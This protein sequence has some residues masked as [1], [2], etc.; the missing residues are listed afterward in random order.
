MEIVPFSARH[1]EQLT[2][3]FSMVPRAAF[4]VATV[5]SPL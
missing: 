2:G 5:T 1:I 4:A 3:L